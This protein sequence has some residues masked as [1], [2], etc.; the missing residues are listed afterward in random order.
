MLLWN[1]YSFFYSFT[2]KYWFPYKNLLED[3]ISAIDLKDGENVLDAGCGPGIVIERMMQEEKNINVTGIDLSEGMVN[4][5]QKRCRKFSDINIFIADL[6][7]R[8]EFED[9]CFDKVVCSNTIYALE[10]PGKVVAELHRVT[11]SGG[12]VVIA[13]PKPNA[14]IMELLKDHIRGI[15]NMSSFWG[16]IYYTILFILLTP[17][18]FIVFTINKIITVK[19]KKSEYHFLSKKELMCITGIFKNIKISSSYANQDWLVRAQK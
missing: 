9:N 1:I 17:L 12:V 14:G 3:L 2:L 7:K 16:K 18:T 11:K 15:C 10:D 19:A 8:L 5:A 4:F 6:N 13:N